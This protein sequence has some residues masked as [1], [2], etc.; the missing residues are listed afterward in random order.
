MRTILLAALTLMKPTHQTVTVL[1]HLNY[2]KIGKYFAWKKK[3][4]QII[5]I[6]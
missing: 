5:F 1:W 3:K 4:D 2:V 6:Y